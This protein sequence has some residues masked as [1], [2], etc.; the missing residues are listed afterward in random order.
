[1]IRA[2]TKTKFDEFLRIVNTMPLQ[3][4]WTTKRGRCLLFAGTVFAVLGITATSFSF[5]IPDTPLI[6]ESPSIQLPKV[7]NLNTTTLTHLNS[8]KTLYSNN[9]T[10]VSPTNHFLSKRG[11]ITVKECV[12]KGEPWGIV[13]CAHLW[14]FAMHCTPCKPILSLSL[15]LNPPH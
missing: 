1:M 14:A 10:I 15:L 3:G 11:G 12:Q 2:D 7:G 6:H 9:T 4:L 13:C 8:S 5:I